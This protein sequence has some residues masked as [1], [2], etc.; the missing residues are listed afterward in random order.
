[1]KI[2]SAEQ[3]RQW[4]QFTIE[5]EPI[6]SVDLME[7]AATK[8]TEWLMENFPDGNRFNI[9]CGKGN[10]GGDGLAIA[11]QLM[12]KDYAVR[13]Y[14]L[15]F[16]H[17]GTADFQVNLA[18]LHNIPGAD[19]HFIQTT[20]HFHEI[21]REEIIIDAIFGS[22]LNR[23]LEGITAQLVQHINSSHCPVVS[24]DIPTGLFTDHSSKGNIIVQADHTLTFQC[25]KAA[26]L[27]PENES[28]AGKVHL[29]DI[30]LSSQYIKAID[31]S[32]ELVDDI[33]V[34]NIY[35][36]RKKFSHKGSFGHALIMAGSYGKMGA[37]V[38]ATKACLRA[39][40]GLVTAYLPSGGNAIMQQSVPEA[41]VA[42]D[43]N[44]SIITELTENTDR[45]DAIGAGPG[46][47]TASETREALSALFKNYNKP[48]VADADALNIIARNIDL[49]KIIPSSS[50]ITPHPKEFERLFGTT[51]NDFERIDLAQKKALEYNIII[52]L[53]GHHT[54]IAL[55]GGKAYFNSTGN[56]GMATA[57]TGDVLTGIIT[58]LLAQGYQPAN[59]AVLG[60]YL[61]GLAGDWAAKQQSEEAM[62]AGDIIENLGKAFRAII[63]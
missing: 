12:E 39:G 30:G 54:L 17:K 16:G 27:M 59:A 26:F 40:C 28:A 38:L 62:I 36:P 21:S 57:G 1:M 5:H 2:L 48:V 18:R 55:P 46:L 58:G 19:I 44:P 22:G 4:D 43:I 61:H 7:R 52:V 24:I 20:D 6:A 50:I 42:T 41:M 10:N 11:R 23:P 33:I 37:A 45:F 3:I 51:A 13:I 14:I 49:L 9:F 60:V 53:K 56:A 47:G 32:Y 31:C 63:A 35:K 15:E 25:F 29:L 34:S 8:C